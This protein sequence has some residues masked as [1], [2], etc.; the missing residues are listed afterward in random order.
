MMTP[1]CQFVIA[2]VAVLITATLFN[3]PFFH[4]DVTDKIAQT[5]QHASSINVALFFLTALYFMI[6]A[7]VSGCR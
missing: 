7:L 3:F 6:A 1:R 5:C 4:G 2:L